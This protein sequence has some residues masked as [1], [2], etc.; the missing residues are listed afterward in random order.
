MNDSSK[1]SQDQATLYR[2]LCEAIPLGIFRNDVTGQCIYANQKLQEMSGLSQ[3]EIL[4]DGWKKMVHPEDQEWLSFIW[5][6]FVEQVNLGHQSHYQLEYRYLNQDNSVGWAFVQAVPEYSSL[7]QL[8]GFIGSTLDITQRKR[9][10]EILTDYS[11]KLENEVNQRTQELVIINEQL[12]Q[13]I[14]ERKKVELALRNSQK[15]LKE[16]TD[17]IHA[18]IAYVDQKG[19]YHFVNKFYELQF[20]RSRET[21]IG[22]Y[23]WEVMGK[24]TYNNVNHLIDQVLKG[25]SKHIEFDITYETG[26]TSY[27]SC[28]LTPAFDETEKVIGYYTVVFDITERRNL[29]QS[30]KKANKKLSYLAVVDDLTEIANRRRFDDFLNKEWRRLLRTQDPLSLI[31]LDVDFFKCYNDYYGHPKGDDCLVKIAQ[32]ANNSV[33]RCSDLVARYGGEEFAVI[34][35]N[36]D[37]RGAIIVAQRIHQN[38]RNARIPHETSKKGSIISVSLGVACLIPSLQESPKNLINLADQA[39]YQAKNQGRDRFCVAKNNNI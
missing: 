28:F 14:N 1:S 26:N 31:L 2:I 7:G 33:S 32:L 34:L 21:M 38:I 11:H 23:V 4:G 25:E 29:E 39:L 10:E 8:V 24:E 5:S 15:Q 30:L 13:E 6:H 19:K 18:G 20:N 22:K 36:T 3:E 16:I 12:Q 35:P 9:A 27:S 17:S 37:K